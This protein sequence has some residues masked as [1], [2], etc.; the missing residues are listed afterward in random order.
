LSEIHLNGFSV[1]IFV[2]ENFDLVNATKK[3]VEEIITQ[4]TSKEAAVN[5]DYVKNNIRETV[6][7]FLYQKTQRRPMILPVVIE[8]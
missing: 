6:G 2:K 7:S 4:K 8:V 5:W 3:K 1:F